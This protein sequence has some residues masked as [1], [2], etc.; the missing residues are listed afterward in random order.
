MALKPWGSWTPSIKRS[1]KVFLFWLP[2]C[3]LLKL[4]EHTFLYDIYKSNSSISMREVIITSIHKDL[5][6]KPLFWGVVW[7]KFNNLWLALGMASKFYNSVAKGWKLKVKKSWGLTPTF[8]EVTGE[9][10]VEGTFCRPLLGL[11]Q[12]ADKTTCISAN[13]HF[14][15]RAILFI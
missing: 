15:T 6:E 4:L 13:I 8:A 10:L 7:F 1:H 14:A 3:Y 12:K 9:K 2:M 5:P 11:K